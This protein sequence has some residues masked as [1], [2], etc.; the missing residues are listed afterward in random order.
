MLNLDDIVM[1]LPYTFDIGDG[2]PPI[3]S[4][5]SGHLGTIVELHPEPMPG[6]PRFAK[7]LCG[8]DMRCRDIWVRSDNLRLATEEE[9]T[10]W[11]SK[12]N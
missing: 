7:I 9:K 11:A 3:P 2:Q 6:F 5:W 8:K 10:E 12:N 4:H 1:I